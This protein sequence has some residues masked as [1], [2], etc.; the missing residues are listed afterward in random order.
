MINLMG[1][2]GAV[3]AFLVGGA[4]CRQSDA[5]PFVFGA[6]MLLAGC[7]LVV[8]FVPV[9]AGDDAHQVDAAAGPDLRGA[10]RS[11]AGVYATCSPSGGMATVRW[12]RCWGRS[13]ACFWP[14]AC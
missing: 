11:Q 7:L 4:L 8:A 2:I 13:S 12:W 3:L 10:L 5:A 14:T 6:A 9:P 1:G